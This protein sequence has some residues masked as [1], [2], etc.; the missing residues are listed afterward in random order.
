MYLTLYKSPIHNPKII[1]TRE[2]ICIIPET[3]GNYTYDSNYDS[4]GFDLIHNKAIQPWILT[5]NYGDCTFTHKLVQF[6]NKKSKTLP[7]FKL[8]STTVRDKNNN[9]SKLV[10][11]KPTLT[12]IYTMELDH[13]NNLLFNR[14]YDLIGNPDT[15]KYIKSQDHYNYEAM[16]V[17]KYMDKL[18]FID[19]I[20][21]EYRNT[22]SDDQRLNLNNVRDIYNEYNLISDLYKSILDY[23]S[24]SPE[25]DR[26]DLKHYL[27]INGFLDH[28]YSKIS[29]SYVRKDP[30]SLL[31]KFLRDNGYL[32]REDMESI[33]SFVPQESKDVDARDKNIKHENNTT[34]ITNEDML[35][36]NLVISIDQLHNVF[37]QY[38]D[39]CITVL[40]EKLPDHTY[41]VKNVEVDICA[42]D[43][44]I[45][46]FDKSAFTNIC[47]FVSVFSKLTKFCNEITSAL[48]TRTPD[49]T[50]LDFYLKDG[51]IKTIGW[52]SVMADAASSSM[53]EV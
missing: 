26:N 49:T 53:C 9:K 27:S 8:V 48:I 36:S 19:S 37:D 33:L 32:T 6:T 28:F 46:I 18:D 1:L 34:E 38:S 2:Q 51:S 3:S 31:H 5:E 15:V 4:S 29:N 42:S 17:N 13:V 40:I 43:I 10:L 44:N 30:R 14:I 39:T 22:D 12:D 41:R 21:K 52:S 7:N 45:E 47:Q 50:T 11:F 20:I 35:D 25:P 16:N 23:R 24:D